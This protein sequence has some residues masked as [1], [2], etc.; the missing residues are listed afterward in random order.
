MTALDPGADRR[1]RAYRAEARAAHAH[2]G[3]PLDGTERAAQTYVDRI[4]RSTWWQHNCPP[5]WLGDDS[6]TTGYFDTSR[7]PRRVIVKAT[8]GVG[9]YAHVNV[10]YKHRGRWFPQ[11]RL[12][13]RDHIHN[14]TPAVA[15]PWVILHELAHIMDA[16]DDKHG[17]GRDFARFML[18]LVR[19]WLGPA[20]AAA[21]RA[22]F[23]TERV[24]YRARRQP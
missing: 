20:H 12:G 3:T 13:T 8:R 18:M 11:I 10:L 22:E 6:D 21:L 14:G 1:L 24:K 7:P 17:H 15:D 5:S 16:A 4:T 2:P 9:G 19:R 23:T